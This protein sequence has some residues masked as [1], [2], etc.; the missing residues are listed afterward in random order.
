MKPSVNGNVP[1]VSLTSLRPDRL[2]SK[3][4]HNPENEAESTAKGA[5]A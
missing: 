4:D 1:A 3:A 2:G 5:Q